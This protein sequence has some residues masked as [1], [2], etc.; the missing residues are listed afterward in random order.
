M[1]E[2]NPNQFNTIHTPTWCPGCGNWG[3]W[4]ALKSALAALGL[5]TEEV[6]IVYGIGCAGNTANWIKTYGF[7]SLHGRTLPVALGV[8]LANYNLKV[9]AISGDGDAYAEGANHFLQTARTN[10]DLTYLVFNNHSFSLTTGQSS[11]TSDQG[12]ISKTT[13][14]GELNMPLNPLSLAL[15]A[16][17]SFVARGYAGDV[18][19]LTE[20]IK[21]GIMH[22][23][24]A[25]ID[26]FQECLTFNKINTSSWYKERIYK[27]AEIQ[28]NTNS[29]QEAWLKAQEEEKL[30]I[31]IF[32]EEQK[33]TFED[34]LNITADI[35]LVEKSLEQKTIVEKLL[36][37][38]K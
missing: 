15:D 26:I 12:Y 7:H 36:N 38:F 27:L 9:L 25:L 20:L 3:I 18:K 29:R 17:A 30:P 22:Q 19:H 35:P 2:L 5:R 14:N 11:P 37:E 6:V 33:P 31:G 13:P 21:L 10:I 16:R 32:Y 34:K 24:F 8:K 28:H 1:S 23:G 4:A